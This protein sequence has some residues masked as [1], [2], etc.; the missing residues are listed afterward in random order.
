MICAILAFVRLGKICRNICVVLYVTRMLSLKV[1]SSGCWTREG[2]WREACMRVMWKGKIKTPTYKGRWVH[3]LHRQH[4]IPYVNSL[5]PHISFFLAFFPLLVP[6]CLIF[7]HLSDR[8]SKCLTCVYDVR[9]CKNCQNN[10]VVLYVSDGFG[11]GKLR[12][13]EM[14]WK[15]QRCMHVDFFLKEK[16][17][18]TKEDRYMLSIFNIPSHGYIFFNPFSYS[19]GFCVFVWFSCT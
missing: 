4:F 10:W 8:L 15:V 1:A 7:T 11:G 2:K 5:H 19:E 9:L 12:L 18:L 16:H 6:F 13:L 3:A 14:G 17:P